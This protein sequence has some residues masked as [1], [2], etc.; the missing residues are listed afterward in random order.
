MLEDY[1]GVFFEWNC[2][3]PRAFTFGR[4]VVIEEGRI[5]EEALL[6]SA[7]SSR[8]NFFNRTAIKIR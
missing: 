4:L 7:S 6:F 5:N 3:T 8:A 2:K 1:E